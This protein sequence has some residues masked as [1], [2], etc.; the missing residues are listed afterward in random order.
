MQP[1]LDDLAQLH[2]Q[3]QGQVVL[4]RHPLSPSDWLASLL[5]PWQAAALE[6]GLD[7]QTDIPEHLPVQT[8]DPDRMAQAVGNLLSNA[9][10]YTPAGGTVSVAAGEDDGALWIRVADTGPGIAADELE[11]IFEPFYRSQRERRFP[12]GL[13]LGLT[14]A[15]NM[16]QA[17][18]GR[19]EVVSTPG[20]GSRFTIVL[21]HEVRMRK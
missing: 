11:M 7:W 1:L 15:R 21:P 9:V 18:G 3:V 8:L 4:N 20:Q 6:K 13:G 2:G 12:Q 16:V 5:L 10:K 19:L 14:I 17:H